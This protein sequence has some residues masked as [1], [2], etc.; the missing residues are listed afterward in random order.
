MIFSRHLCEREG[1]TCTTLW[2]VPRLLIP[3]PHAIDV[4]RRE[5]TQEFAALLAAI[6]TAGTSIPKVQAEPYLSTRHAKTQVDRID[7]SVE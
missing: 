4:M 2:P 1:S 6:S 7:L 3:H 5:C